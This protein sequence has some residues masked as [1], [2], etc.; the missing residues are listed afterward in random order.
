MELI[1][2]FNPISATS[3][4]FTAT[5]L[6]YGSKVVV[7]NKTYVDMIFTFSNGDQH[8]VLA[9][10]TRCFTF[11]DANATPGP[12]VKW[13][14][15]NID[16]PQTVKQLENVCYIEIYAATEELTESFPTLIARES[17]PNLIPYENGAASLG[18]V[19]APTATSKLTIWPTSY[20]GV[21]VCPSASGGQGLDH[22]WSYQNP[23][24]ANML[25]L[26]GQYP[27]TGKTGNDATPNN[28]ALMSPVFG[29]FSQAGLPPIDTATM[30]N[31]TYWSLAAAI[32]WNQASGFIVDGFLYIPQKTNG[33]YIIADNA[34]GS[35]SGAA[36]SV[37]TTTGQ[38]RF[39]VGDSSGTQIA[40]QNTVP[41]G[42]W[43]YFAAVYTG[44]TDNH[45]QLWINNTMVASAPTVSAITNTG[46]IPR[47]GSRTGAGFGFVGS[48][49]N[50]GISLNN[51]QTLGNPLARYEHFQ[52]SL[53]TDYQNVWLTR[54]DL[55]ISSVAALAAMT[56]IILSNVL[57]DGGLYYATTPAAIDS[58]HKY[59]IVNQ[60]QTFTFSQLAALQAIQYPPIVYPNPI[61]HLNDSFLQF[62]ASMSTGTVFPQVNYVVHGYNILNIV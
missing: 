5:T 23:L 58:L 9:N 22:F 36:I 55:E 48:I 57:N 19:S 38:L 29:P 12:L 59:F 40:S 61:S 4:Q 21:S 13:T 25:D 44:T 33:G 11:S 31:N 45:I 3:G 20:I 41:F 16:Y 24:H 32:P 35:T 14:Q 54:L 53:N 51:P 7:R 52:Q 2:P 10:E 15:E 43:F 1:T 47:I 26:P 39:G 27:I 56:N 18:L 8:P 62:S 37:D 28:T 34:I 6:Q 42:Q 46:N 30:L 49:C 17:T 60:P 50:L